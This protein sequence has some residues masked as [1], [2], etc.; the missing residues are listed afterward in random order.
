MAGM[1]LPIGIQSF[2]EMRTGG[3]AYVDKTPLIHSLTQSGKYY[4]LSRPRRFGKSLLID[5]CD[6]AFSGRQDLFSGLY[7]DSQEAEW[8]WKKRNPVLRIDWSLSS[9]RRPEELRIQI[10]EILSAWARQWDFEPFET[11]IGGRFSALV[12]EIHKKAGE[13]V[14]ILVDEYDKPILDTLEDSACAAE[15]RDILRDFYGVIKPLDPHLRFVLLTGVSKFVKTGIFSGLNNLKDITLD[16]RYS[17][18]CGYTEEDIRTVFS[19]WYQRS[20]PSLVREWYNGYSWTGES[21]YNPFDILLYFDSGIFRPY[22][23]ETGTPSFLI[24][25]WKNEPRLPAE[26]DGMVSGDELLLSCNPENIHVDTL[27]FQA[28]YLTI[29]SWSSDGIRGFRCTLGY[30]N[31]EVRTSLNLLFSEALTG[32]SLSDNR[33]KLF[34]LLGSGDEKGLYTHLQSFFASIP[35]DWHRKNPLAAFEGYW[36]SL[37][38]SYI[39]SLGYEVTPEDTTNKGRIDLTVKTPSYIWIFEFKMKNRDTKGVKGPLDQIHGTGYAEKFRSDPRKRIL[40]GIVFDPETR[41]IDSW[42]AQ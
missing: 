5:T 25:L 14:V 41:N 7:L 2:V 28:G 36:A 24:T 38:Y 21:V 34:T 35:H 12:R 42:T 19:P 1:K 27:L 20:D 9:P 6:C 39:A 4:F 18:I 29:R 10:D 15:M 30:P 13:Q 8:D 26:Y 3:Y 37:I 40:V 23:F 31:K 33:N 32:Y 17:S 16:S 22:W 11:S